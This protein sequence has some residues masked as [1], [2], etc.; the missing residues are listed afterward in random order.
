MSNV[1]WNTIANYNLNTWIIQIILLIVC[2]ALTISLYLKP[3]PFLKKFIKFYVGIIFLWIGIVFFYTYG[4]AEAKK[5]LTGSLF[6][7]IGLLWIIDVLWKKVDFV[8]EKKANDIYLHIL[9]FMAFISGYKY[10]IWKEIP[11]NKY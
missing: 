8:F 2:I 9:C 4:S 6:I 1:F 7:I 5:Y 11:I 3:T 10:A